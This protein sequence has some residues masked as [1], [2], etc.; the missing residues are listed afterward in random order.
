MTEVALID[1]TYTLGDLIGVGGMGSVYAAEDADHHGVAVKL[2]HAAL[3]GDPK[4]VE[5]F[6]EEAR[7][8]QHVSHRNVVRVIG[9]GIGD[10]GP[11]LVMERVRGTPLGMLI[12]DEGPLRLSRIRGIALQILAGLAAIHR[13]GLVHGD[14]KSDNVLVECIDG[15]DHVVLIDFG[16]ARAPGTRVLSVEAPLVSGTPEYLAPELIRGE[17]ISSR[18]DLYAVG[19]TIYEMLTGTTPFAGGTVQTIFDRHLGDD[20]VPPS[21]RC[22]DRA[23]P[24]AFEL[25]V[26]RA[27]EKEVARRHQDAE[28]F[29][30]AIERTLPAGSREPAAPR[31]T[32][33]FST[34]APTR[35][36]IRPS[37]LDAR[38]RI[39][40][41]APRCDSERVRRRR[42]VVRGALANNDPDL[43]VVGY[44]G[45]AQAL[46]EE[47][48]LSA[49]ARELE[50]G[51][52][53]LSQT[54][55]VALWRIVLTLAAIYDGLHDRELARSTA[56]AAYEH[57][58]RAGSSLGESRSKALLR[59]LGAAR[60]RRP[61][62]TARVA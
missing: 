15:V 53:S 50:A 5:R 35:D 37:N 33:S 47:H 12:H 10:D 21:L 22:E 48:Q 23:I 3:A 8:A 36:S 6:V 54:M 60:N 42:D 59:R 61:H 17:L 20:V 2:L 57:A 29:A 25:A 51:V 26:M 41:G 7:V 58:R 1:K 18:A 62:P 39:A 43:V 31:H 55:D 24:V 38:R 56:Q 27:L 9:H 13:A 4:M 16:L 30:L 49:A 28:S 34:N 40:G 19:I 32:G 45:I 44:L 52:A 14:I 46:V 11:F